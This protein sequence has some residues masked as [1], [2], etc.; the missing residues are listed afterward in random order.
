MFRSG[1]PL[2]DAQ[3]KGTFG[4]GAVLLQAV[5]GGGSTSLLLSFLRE[6][7]LKGRDVVYVDLKAD[8]RR[9]QLEEYLGNSY[10]YVLPEY[11]EAG[12]DAV[13]H[14]LDC[15]VKV[16]GMDGVDFIT[17]YYYEHLGL[18]SAYLKQ[19]ARLLQQFRWSVLR[20]LELRQCLVVMTANVSV[21]LG[22]SSGRVLHTPVKDILA[23]DLCG[24]LH[25]NIAGQ[26]EKHTKVLYKRIEIS[27]FNLRTMHRSRDECVRATLWQSGFN[28]DY[29]LLTALRVANIITKQ[30][31]SYKFEGVT[32]ERS[33]ADMLVF[34]RENYAGLYDKAMAALLSAETNEGD[35]DG[36][37]D[38]GSVHS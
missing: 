14:A 32:I 31:A 28:R 6:E 11:G 20:T 38:T 16:I 35:D 36:A 22:G 15:G 8:M 30:N 24:Y 27:Q 21:D 2:V 5:P 18:G 34:V 3:N 17:P 9:A 4:P 19:Q 37:E 12:V 23:D 13:E 10:V 7:T 25:L 26:H 29:E 1:I 33:T